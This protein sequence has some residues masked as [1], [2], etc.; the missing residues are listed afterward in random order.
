M[1]AQIF[2]TQIDVYMPAQIFRLNCH[3]L[4]SVNTKS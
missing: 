4:T 3:H 2:N 1:P